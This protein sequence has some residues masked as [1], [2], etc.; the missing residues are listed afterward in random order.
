MTSSETSNKIA[1][2]G[3]IAAAFV[4]AIHVHWPWADS[5]CAKSICSSVF[6]TAV[7]FFFTVSGYFLAA[8]FEEAGWWWRAVRKRIRTLLVPYFACLLI[9]LVLIAAIDV[10][11]NLLAGRPPLCHLRGFCGSFRLFFGLYPFAYPEVGALWYIRCLCCFVLISPVIKW[12]DDQLGFV[13]LLA[14]AAGMLC[15]FELVHYGVLSGAG[16]HWG[17][18]FQYGF[19]PQGLLFFSLGVHLRRRPCERVWIGRLFVPSVFV[20]VLILAC[21]L[22]VPRESLGEWIW[23][24]FVSLSTFTFLIVFWRIVPSRPWPRALTSCS[25]AIYILHWVLFYVYW[26]FGDQ[27]SGAMGWAYCAGQWVYGFVG[28]IV[29]FRLLSR[30]LP[31][32]TNVLFGGRVG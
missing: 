14:V 30:Y 31:K 12:L 10:S 16:G 25:F 21:R 24:F 19:S 4:V 15:V 11:C 5:S 18:F 29:V 32:F 26:A 20:T 27:P 6:R 1:N 2:F 22:A 17:N 13:Y 7:P 23:P 28:P 8:R 3:L 9:A